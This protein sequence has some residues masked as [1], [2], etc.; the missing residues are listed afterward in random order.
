MKT[1]IYVTPLFPE[2][3]GWRCAYG[4][5]FAHALKATGEF[6]VEV[7]VEGNSPD[8][9]IGGIK[10]HTFRARM[11][12]SNVLPFAMRKWNER[13]FLNAVRRAGIKIEDVAVCHGNTA[14]YAIYPLALKR[15]NQSCLAILHHHDLGSFGLKNGI[16]W[17]FWPY[18]MMMFPVLRRLHEQID[19]HVFISRRSRDSFIAAPDASWTD[20]GYYTKQMRWLPYGP[21]RIKKS[22]ILHNGVDRTIFTPKGRK[23]HDGFVIGCVGNFIELKDQM[24]LLKAVKMLSR[25]G[26][27]GSGRAVGVGGVRVVFVG[28]G[29]K[30]RECERY[31]REHGIDAEFRDEVQHDQ[32]A[33]FYR[34]LDLFV[35]SSFFEGF[36]CVYTEAWCCGTPFIACEGQGIEEVVP[37]EDRGK[38]LCRKRDPKDLAAK[39]AGYIENRW[40]QRLTEDPDING[41]VERFI[42]SYVLHK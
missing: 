23:P 41:L 2:P 30:R 22:A 34:G 21:A 8:Y 33:D 31:A 1:Y 18:N 15:E 11:M 17:H 36:G 9:E 5:D 42:K 19:M 3:G 7:F 25:V 24:T 27:S 37:E 40:E 16:L 12:P 29:P 4:Y 35:L 20:Y 39:I 26:G 10:V 13:S 38:W 28:S 32:L 14:N 6:N